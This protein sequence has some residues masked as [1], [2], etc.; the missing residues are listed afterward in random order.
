MNQNYFSYKSLNLLLVI[1]MMTVALGACVTSSKALPASQETSGSPTAEPVS[2]VVPSPVDFNENTLM[3]ASYLLPDIGEVQL[4]DG[5]FEQ[6]YGEGATQVNQV[7]FNKMAVEQ[8]AP[9]P[10]RMGN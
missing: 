5:H 3:N 7:D 4:K 8:H 10:Y 6:K 2:T 1:I 9:M